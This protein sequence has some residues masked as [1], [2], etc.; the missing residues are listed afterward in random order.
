[1]MGRMPWH[2]MGGAVWDAW[3]EM[4][5]LDGMIWMEGD[6]WMG[7]MTGYAATAGCM[8]RQGA[9]DSPLTQPLSSGARRSLKDML[10]IQYASLPYPPRILKVHT[11]RI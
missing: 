5:G 9:T 4:H 8:D 3:D 10:T 11:K 1:M 2:C 6:V 7:W